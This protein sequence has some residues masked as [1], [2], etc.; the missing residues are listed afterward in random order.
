M[1]GFQLGLNLGSLLPI[2][3][4][5]NKKCRRFGNYRLLDGDYDELRI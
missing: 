2:S 4:D 5:D 1:V 3:Y